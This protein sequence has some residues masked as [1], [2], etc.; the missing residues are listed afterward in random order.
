VPNNNIHPEFMHCFNITDE[1][2]EGEALEFKEENKFDL[3]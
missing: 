2:P 1:I 3:Y